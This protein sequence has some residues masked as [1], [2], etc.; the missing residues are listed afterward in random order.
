MAF[1]DG[2]GER[3]L[4][5]DADGTSVEVLCLRRELSAVPSFEFALRERAARLA[6]FQHGYFSHVR[7]VDR[8]AT[9]HHALTVASDA[10]PGLRLSELL[11]SAHERGLAVP[12][13]AALCLIRQLV[14]AVAI[15]HYQE[16]GKESGSIARI[17]DGEKILLEQGFDGRGENLSHRI[18]AETMAPQYRALASKLGGPIRIEGQ[19]VLPVGW[20]LIGEPEMEA[21]PAFLQW[22]ETAKEDLIRSGKK[23]SGTEIARLLGVSQ[24]TFNQVE[25]GVKTISLDRLALWLRIWAL[26]AP[27]ECRR[28]KLEVEGAEV[29]LLR[30]LRLS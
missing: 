7:S 30:L 8:S 6:Q 17:H 29:R 26:A 21:R 24:P 19:L 28:W 13:G 9:F 18:I 23:G 3:R 20:K 2:L 25:R 14:P 27:N 15:L 4:I 5:A 22:A 10:V 11:A 12:I 16:V 1:R